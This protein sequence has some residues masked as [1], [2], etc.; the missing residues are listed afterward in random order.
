MS[1]IHD[2]DKYIYSLDN[3][4]P[5]LKFAKDKYIECKNDLLENGCY[6]YHPNCT[7]TIDEL[8][9]AI[10]VINLKLSLLKKY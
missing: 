8:N 5:L 3:Y 6:K 4:L 9:Y 7:Y 10:K 2:I 1:N